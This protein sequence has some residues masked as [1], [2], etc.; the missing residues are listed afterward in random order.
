MHDYPLGWQK[1][2]E[3]VRYTCSCSSTQYSPTFIPDPSNIKMF[4]CRSCGCYLSNLQV[5]SYDGSQAYRSRVAEI[6]EQRER[7]KRNAHTH[8]GGEH[9]YD[10]VR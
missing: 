4:F 7:R 5:D 3:G 8:A 10:E 9:I 6:E 2:D 1:G